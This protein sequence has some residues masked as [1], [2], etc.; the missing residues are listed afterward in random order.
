M[1]A[2]ATQLQ[3]HRAWLI[4]QSY[5]KLCPH[6]GADN[7]GIGD[8]PACY[9]CGHR[10][11]THKE[12]PM[13]SIQ[14]FTTPSIQP[15]HWITIITIWRA[16]LKIG[17]F[18]HRPV[19]FFKEHCRQPSQGVINSDVVADTDRVKIAKYVFPHVTWRNT[20]ESQFNQAIYKA[21]ISQFST[22]VFKY[23]STADLTAEL[24]RRLKPRLLQRKETDG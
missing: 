20:D 5:C 16:P 12:L 2:T 15:K 19:V 13:I 22:G 9:N 18:N 14:H 17:L 6:C 7:Q 4:E 11:Y 1:T 8:Q 21:L 3:A 24:H 23:I 10:L